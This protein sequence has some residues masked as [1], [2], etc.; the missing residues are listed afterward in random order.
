MK[1]KNFEISP[2]KSLDGAIYH[3]RQTEKTSD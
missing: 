2:V 3:T 1:F